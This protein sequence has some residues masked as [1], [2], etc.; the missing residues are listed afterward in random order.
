MSDQH[1]LEV[2]RAEIDKPE[3]SQNK[4]AAELG[5]STSKLSQTLR[6]IYPGSTEDIQLK[7]ESIYMS[8]TVFCPALKREISLAECDGNQ[9]RPFSSANRERV[10]LYKACRSGCE[11]SKLQQ[12]ASSKLIPVSSADGDI[13]NIDNQLAYLRREAKGNQLRLTELMEAELVKL[14]AR[15]NQ[16]LWKSKY[17]K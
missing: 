2:L 14:A 17:Q 3:Q 15:Y 10:K 16:L 7:V 6:G 13:Y 9:N 8:K 11:H 12:T 4:V 1:W 5:I